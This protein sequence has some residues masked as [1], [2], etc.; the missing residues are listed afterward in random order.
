M[1]WRL[2]P[3]LSTKCRQFVISHWGENILQQVNERPVSWVRHEANPYLKSLRRKK[4][5]VPFIVAHGDANRIELY[6]STEKR[7]RGS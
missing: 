6:L 2:Y 1:K 5:N 3:E 4:K 7:K